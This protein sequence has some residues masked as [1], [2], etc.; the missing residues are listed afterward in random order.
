MLINHQV[1]VHH[2]RTLNEY[3]HFMQMG[4]RQFMAQHFDCHVLWVAHLHSRI[5][6]PWLVDEHD[7]GLYSRLCAGDY[8]EA[9][10]AR[11][12]GMLWLPEDKVD[13]HL[14]FES[15]RYSVLPSL[16]FRDYGE[17][18]RRYLQGAASALHTDDQ[19]VG[20]LA[21]HDCPLF[22][23]AHAQLCHVV[24][25]HLGTAVKP[26]YCYLG[27][28]PTGS[29]LRRHTDRPQCAYNVSIVFDRQVSGRRAEPWPIY[30]EV[31]GQAHELRLP[32][33]HGVLYQGTELPHWRDKLESGT[34]T[35]CFF[36]F[37]VPEFQGGLK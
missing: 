14:T 31:E 4:H 19:V 16:C 17:T 20:R 35:A 9:R 1:H 25:R 10:T 29:V 22:V 6:W 36:H 37:V 33:G 7:A 30:L 27:H 3:P 12:Y 23:H 21:Q 5:W 28:Y 34:A 2:S 13:E 32:E 8:S 26:S 18:V 15:N 11:K 24:Q